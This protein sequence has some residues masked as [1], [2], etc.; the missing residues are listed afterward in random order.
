[1]Q[2]IKA[3]E[4]PGGPKTSGTGTPIST[5]F[6]R[7]DRTK[8]GFGGFGYYSLTLPVR[9]YLIFFCHMDRY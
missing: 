5:I 3:P 2:I 4:D 8:Q 6:N 7:R 9:A 1:M